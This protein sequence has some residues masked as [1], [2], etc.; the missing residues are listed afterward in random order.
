MKPDNVLSSLIGLTVGAI[1]AAA[2][3]FWLDIATPTSTVYLDLAATAA[4]VLAAMGAV[5]LT[6]HLRD[7]GQK[8]ENEK[9]LEARV[10]DTLLEL[11]HM[12]RHAMTMCVIFEQFDEAATVPGSVYMAAFNGMGGRSPVFD[13]HVERIGVL[14][15]KM[16][17]AIREAYLLL[18]DANTLA[19]SA[20]KVDDKL[21]WAVMDVHP[22][23]NWKVY[24]GEI[25]RALTTGAIAELTSIGVEPTQDRIDTLKND[26][27]VEARR[28]LDR[29]LFLHGKRERPD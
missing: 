5:V 11:R 24:W 9:E 10:N 19:K 16:G 22:S 3:L 15:P 20:I 26:L 1:F 27:R 29:G 4:T 17:R 25:D 18:S 12:L 2:L 6:Q 8:T 7:R 28:R 13:L 23:K 21:T 14:D